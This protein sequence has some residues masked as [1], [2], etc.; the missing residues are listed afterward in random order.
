VWCNSG[1]TVV[2]TGGHCANGSYIEWNGVFS[3]L[4]QA[5]VQC[6]E[7]DSATAYAVCCPNVDE[8]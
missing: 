4:E 5:D 3:G 6:S 2:A 7:D 8:D 1:E